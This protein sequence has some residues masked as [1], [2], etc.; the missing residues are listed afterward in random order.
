MFSVCLDSRW[1]SLPA[2]LEDHPQFSS[3][4]LIRT[5]RRCCAK[6]CERCRGHHQD[7]AYHSICGLASCRNESLSGWVGDSARFRML[8]SESCSFWCLGLFHPKVS[9][10]RVHQTAIVQT[11][12]SMLQTFPLAACVTFSPGAPLASSAASTISHLPSFPEAIWPRSCVP[13]A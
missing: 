12:S 10:H 1:F 13:A 5:F 11:N 7:Q 3:Y 9:E 8:N 4:I 6:G 2:Q